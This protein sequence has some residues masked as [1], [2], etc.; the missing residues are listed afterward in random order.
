[1]R[2]IL[3]LFS[4]ALFFLPLVSLKVFADSGTF[5]ATDYHLNTSTDNL[6]FTISDPDPTIDTPVYGLRVRNADT[7]DDLYWYNFDDPDS[8]NCS[9]FTAC[10]LTV[11]V[12]SFSDVSNVYIVF[13]TEGDDTI[14]QSQTFS[15]DS[16]QE[17][18]SIRITSSPSSGTK[19]VGS[20]F[21]VDITI[22]NTGDEAFNAARATVTVSSNLSITGIHN[23]SSN[24]CNFNYTKTPTTADPSFA[25]AIYGSSSTG[26]TVYTM[27]LTPTSTGT[28][29]ITFTDGSI[30]AYDDNSEILSDVVNGSFTIGT[31]PTP[32][33]TASLDFAI[34]NLLQTYDSSF[35]LTGTKLSTITQMFVNGSD[36]DSSYPTDTTWEAEVSLSLGD[37]NF[38]IYGSDGTDQTATQTITVNRHTLGDINGDG[39]IDLID[40]SLFATDW[41]KTSDLT[42]NLSDMNGDGHVDLTDLSI[43]AKLE[44]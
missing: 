43:L 29:S 15:L 12:D 27:T 35:T 11:N 22:D 39:N 23:P 26:C 30:K 42:Y 7:G 18:P 4:L 19:T 8:E 5:T 41:D 2:K 14:S 9:S 6:T 16:L 31:G 10:N 32:T 13:I 1:M 40:A 17:T 37:N 38:A 34:T 36:A 44:E 25:G 33:P 28:G 20:P 21:N 24:A 3:V